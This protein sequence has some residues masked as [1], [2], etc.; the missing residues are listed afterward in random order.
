MKYTHKIIF[1]LISIPILVFTFIGPFLPL[2]ISHRSDWWEARIFVFLCVLSFILG[3]SFAA[4][5]LPSE[6]IRFMTHENAKA[7]DKIFVP[8]IMICIGLVPLVAGI[9]SLYNWSPIFGLQIKILSLLV[10][11]AG[12]T[13]TTYAIIENRY[14][15]SVVRIQHDRGHQVISSGPYRW[16]RHPGYTG[17]ILTYITVP[18]FLDSIWSIIPALFLTIILVIRTTLEDKTLQDELKGY[19]EYAKRV[20]YRLFP[21]LW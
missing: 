12:S 5:G 4:P 8:L 15:S 18:F 11:I 17:I 14:F 19:R 1:Y 9:D 13:L 10:M 20:Q 16:I 2:I 7:W 21:G 6:R 3:R